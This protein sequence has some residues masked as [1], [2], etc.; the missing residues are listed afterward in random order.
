MAVAHAALVR[1]VPSASGVVNQAPTTVQLT[2]SEPVEPR[3]ASISV[4][5]AAGQ[6]MTTGQPTRAGTHAERPAGQARTRAG[7]S[8]TS[9]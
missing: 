6:S 3:F 5:D 8:S 2:F 9:G 4:T 7:T 1:T